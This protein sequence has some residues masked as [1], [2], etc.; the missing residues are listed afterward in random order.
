MAGCDSSV[1][2]GRREA[3][4]IAVGGRLEESQNMP[5]STAFVGYTGFVGQALLRQ[6]DFDELFNRSNIETI[7][8][9]KYSLVVCAGAPAQKWYANQHPDEDRANLEWLRSC[10]SQAK[11]E[12]FV[13]ISTVDVYPEP[14]GVDEGTAIYPQGGEPYGRHRFLLERFVMELFA[15]HTVVRLPGLFGLGLKKNTIFDFLTTGTSAFTN[16]E[17]VFQYYAVD[18]L[19]FDI[20]RIMDTELPLL[21][22]ATEP[23]GAQDIAR[24]CSVPLRWESEAP[25][26]VYDMRTRHAKRFGSQGDYLYTAEDVLARL[27]AFVE[28]TRGVE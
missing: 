23:V 20:R 13:L 14:V 16:P 15:N 12:R 27:R 19:W 26:V 17:S 5:M 25:R 18:D 24:A 6:V 4:Q 11:T 7:R 1:A 9:K 22:L 3:W 8:G 10:L 2:S 21:N 28:Q